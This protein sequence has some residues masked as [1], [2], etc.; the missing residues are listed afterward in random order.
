MKNKILEYSLKL[1]KHVIQNKKKIIINY[2]IFITIMIALILIDQLTKTFIFKHGDVFKFEFDKYGNELIQSP[3]SIGNRYETTW[4]SP[5]SIYP[6]DPQKWGGN[7][8]MGTRF[9][10]HRGVTFLPS[11]VN[12]SVIQFI[13]MLILIIGITVPLF[14]KRK[15]LIVALAIVLAGD[16]GNMLDRFMFRGYVKDL[17]YWPWLEKWLNKSIGTFNFADT[18][19]MVGAILSIISIIWDVIE[20]SIAEKKKARIEKDKIIQDEI[21]PLQEEQVV[22]N[23]DHAKPEELDCISKTNNED[24]ILDE[25]VNIQIQNETNSIEIETTIVSDESIVKKEKAPIKKSSR[26]KKSIVVST[27][28]KTSKPTTKKPVSKAKTKKE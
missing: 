24:Q 27:D 28:S 17:F 26:S 2:I 19:V 22:Q 4:I 1:K 8:F 11:G 5:Q 21:S 25:L 15:I 13:S 18:C 10:W 14:T 7:A 16:F 6:N 23:T 9:I 20:T 3:D 12:I